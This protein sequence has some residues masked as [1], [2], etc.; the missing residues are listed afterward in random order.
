MSFLSAGT[1]TATGLAYT[2]D[3]S[4]ALVIQTNNGVTAVTFDTN[5]N[6]TF[7]N[8]VTVTGNVV[9]N[10]TASGPL[11]VNTTNQ[12]TAI[13]NGGTSGVGNIGSASK[14][15]NTVF[16]LATTA[17]Y[18]DLAEKYL[19]DAAYAP[20]TV[21]VFGGSAEV[22]VSTVS[23]DPAVA[24]V[25]STNPAHLM[26]ADIDG[27]AVALTGRVPCKV[28]GPIAKGDRLV[29]SSLAGVAERLDVNKFTPGCIIGKSLG[30]ISSTVVE[31]IEI[32]IGRF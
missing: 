12:P 2:A 16:A 28:L 31:T 14:T 24:G 7:A 18:A 19:A 8:T 4:G 11:T 30:E 15:F 25:V 3:T 1:T 6:A 9:A 22:T 26:N 13:V 20:G 23:H 27:P 32:S 21:L 10:V 5:Q 17:Q 29:T